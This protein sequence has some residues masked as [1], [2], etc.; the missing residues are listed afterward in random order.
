MEGVAQDPSILPTRANSE[1]S[2]ACLVLVGWKVLSVCFLYVDRSV[3]S[4]VSVSFVVKCMKHE[5]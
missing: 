2:P 4:G 3:F 1:M 5:G